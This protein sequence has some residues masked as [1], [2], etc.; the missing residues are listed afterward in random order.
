MMPFP[1]PRLSASILARGG[2]RAIC[3]ASFLCASTAWAQTI[4]EGYVATR[5]GDV[6]VM[7]PSGAVD[8]DIAIRV[9]PPIADGDEAAGVVRRWAQSHPL[10]GADPTALRLKSETLS[11]V[12]S[13]HRIWK[14]GAQA[15][16]EL[17]LM[18]Q[19]GPGRYQP[20]LAR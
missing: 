17:I 4:P 3:V 2:L 15:G 11:G 18:P 14:I 19:V 6:I 20:V 8:P 13:L 10:A 5:E 16:Q 7:R 1:S 9:Y 12:P